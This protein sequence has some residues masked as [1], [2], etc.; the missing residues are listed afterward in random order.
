MTDLGKRTGTDYSG[1]R[2]WCLLPELL[3]F[4]IATAFIAQCSI[5]GN[6]SRLFPYKTRL[7]CTRGVILCFPGASAC[8]LAAALDSLG[9]S[10]PVERMYPVDYPIRETVSNSHQTT[11]PLSSN[12]D[13]SGPKERRSKPVPT[14]TKPLGYLHCALEN[15]CVSRFRSLSILG[16]CQ[17]LRVSGKRNPSGN[18]AMS[19]S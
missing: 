7:R 15:P 1:C 13:M 10:F 9:S 14:V 12:T 16:P 11:R 17:S 18:T 5:N 6:N 2:V 4:S 19:L 8:P 3:S